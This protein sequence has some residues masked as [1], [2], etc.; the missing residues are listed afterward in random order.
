MKKNKMMRLASGLLV[1]VLL[2]TSMISGTFAKYVTS[3]DAN[4]TARVAKWGV[5]VVV[6]GADLFSNEYDGTVVSSVETEDVVAPGTKNDEGVAFSLKG[7]PEV[8]VN[9][10]I[11]VTNVKDVFLKAGNY[12]DYT[13]GNDE[14][15]YFS[16][17]EDYYPLVFT[18]TNGNGDVL[19]SGK[20]S[21]IK[22][23]LEGLSKDYAANTNLAELAEKTDGS[24]KLTWAWDF[25]TV[26]NEVT[27]KKDTLL[28]N[29]AADASLQAKYVDSRFYPMAVDQEYCNTVSF[30]IKITV[31][32]ID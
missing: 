2:T 14:K 22:T 1:A 25:P 4:D 21:E 8:A 10:S 7:T 27:D 3:A 9:V 29:M 16:F 28:G 13:T 5:E 24:Y 15:D 31:T 18:L 30:D 6:E 17:S 26:E 19:A 12:A 11:E 32:Q 23:Y 20:M